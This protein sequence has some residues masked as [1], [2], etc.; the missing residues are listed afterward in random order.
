[1]QKLAI[2]FILILC[3]CAKTSAQHIFEQKFTICEFENFCLDCGSPQAKPPKNFVQEIYKNL[4]LKSLKRTSGTIQLQ[5]IVNSN[6]K[7]CLLSAENK[8]NTSVKKL[9][10]ESAINQT[11]NWY[12]AISENI[13]MNSSITLI[14]DFKEGLIG[15]SR[16]NYDMNMLDNMTVVGEPETEGTNAFKLSYDFVVYNQSNSL[17][18]NNMTRTVAVDKLNNVWI[19]T[20][21]GLVMFDRKNMTIYTNKNS[22]IK[23][24]AYDE[25]QTQ[26]IFKI[27][28]DDSN[29]LWVI[30]GW[31]TYRYNGKNWT[32]L[33]SMNSPLYWPRKIFVDKQNLIWFSSWEGIS[34][35]NG[36]KWTS[37]N[38]ANSSLPTNQTLSI[39]K[40]SKERIWIGTF[41]GNTIIPNEN[42]P[43]LN[44][45]ESPLKKYRIS[46]MLEDSKGNVWFSLCNESMDLVCI[47]KLD[48]KNKWTRIPI[49]NKEIEQNAINNMLLDESNGSLWIASNNI[50]LARFDLISEKWEIYTPL[51][52]NLPSTY[53]MELNQDKDGIIWGATFAGVI[54]IKKK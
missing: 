27:G 37:I 31:E 26:T 36:K 8:T 35:Y 5:V 9:G 43:F 17:L 13:P 50:G 47:Y 32:V 20:D 22:G 34:N 21:N 53:V 45:P 52:S 40:D 11:S 51:N 33:D 4:N 1:M 44:E 16:V 18:P 49:N 38:Q 12:P 14:L 24:K 3:P 19:G 42:L 41:K 23:S 48:N 7:P 29:D 10:L 46:Q 30:G 25:N 28:F 2:L 6:G 39:Y 54:S 15:V